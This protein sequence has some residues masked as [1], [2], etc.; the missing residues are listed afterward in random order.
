M[1]LELI[2]VSGVM[3]KLIEEPSRK[4]LTKRI[5]ASWKPKTWVCACG[6]TNEH[7][8]CGGCGARKT[9]SAQNASVT[10]DDAAAERVPSK[11]SSATTAPTTIGSAGSSPVPDPN[12]GI[13]ASNAA[14]GD[15]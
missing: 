9:A 3:F 12:Q 14:G 5:D 11:A 15:P 6:R 7:E 8:F 13:E 4:F 2:L 10:P 1:V